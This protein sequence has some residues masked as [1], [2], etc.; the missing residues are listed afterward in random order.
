MRAPDSDERRYRRKTVLGLAVV[1]IGVL[2]LLLVLLVIVVA[3]LTAVDEPA[4]QRTPPGPVES[5]PDGSDEQVLEL[6]RRPMLEL[7]EQAVQPQPIS[8]DSAEP[9]I[10]IPRVQQQPGDWVPSDTPG[11]PEGALA[12][13]ASLDRTALRG[14]DPSVYT[15]GFTEGAEPGAPPA[16]DTGLYS[17][18]RSLRTSAGFE[19]AGMVPGLNARYQP[20]HGQIKGTAENGRFVVTCVL[21][22]FSTD[23]R[24]QVVTAGIGDCQAMRWNG[25]EWRIAATPLAAPAPS[26]WPG[27]A[28]A[29]AAGYR[30]LREG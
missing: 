4:P 29:V 26:A 9:P 20:T 28:D 23:Y 11:T 3:R 1:T 22:Q 18:L 17:L 8:S 2:A 10:R 30:D 19:P 27:S 24:G 15:R 6:V 14:A 7:P 21:G 13:L 25:R 12:Q 5:A 16:D